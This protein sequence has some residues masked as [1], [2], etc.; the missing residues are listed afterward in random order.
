MA[1]DPPF[2]TLNHAAGEL[3][4]PSESALLRIGIS[5]SQRIRLAFHG[6]RMEES[7]GDA[8]APAAGPFAPA[9]F[10]VRNF[11]EMLVRTRRNERRVVEFMAAHDRTAAAEK[12]VR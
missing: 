6:D 2:A 4:I 10:A 8:A 7:S 5:S 1:N 11:H 12:T 9:I 3:G